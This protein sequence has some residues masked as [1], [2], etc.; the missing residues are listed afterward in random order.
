MLTPREQAMSA[1]N[2]ALSL[3]RTSVAGADDDEMAQI[4]EQRLT[5]T[6]RAARIIDAA[7]RSDRVLLREPDDD[8]LDRMLA[9]VGA[10][11]AE[12]EANRA[13]RSHDGAR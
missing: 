6:R 1:H 8:S 2:A 9:R 4:Y 7:R 11:E 13:G 12:L 10:L 5:F 3:G